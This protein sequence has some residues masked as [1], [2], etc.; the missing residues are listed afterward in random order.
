[1]INY[2][3]INN[4][5]VSRK[6]RTEAILNVDCWALA[7]REKTDK[8]SSNKKKAIHNLYRLEAKD[9]DIIR[10]GVTYID[11]MIADAVY[12][13]YKT[14]QFTFSEGMILRVLSGD[15]KQ[16]CRQET[17]DRIRKSLE[18]MAGIDFTL[19]CKEEMKARERTDFFNIVDESFIALKKGKNGNYG[20]T[21]PPLYRYAETINQIIAIP[22]RLWSLDHKKPVNDSLENIAIKH[23]LLSRIVTA[24]YDQREKKYKNLN[25]IYYYHPSHKTIAEWEHPFT[26]MLFDLG[27]VREWEKA[28]GKLAK[29]TNGDVEEIRGILARLKNRTHKNTKKILNALKE[30]GYIEECNDIKIGREIIGVEIQPVKTLNEFGRDANDISAN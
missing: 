1:M 26:G 21:N 16:T 11:M 6:I 10:E 29:V 3:Y 28:N 18:K 4:T 24:N 7:R 12:S 27:V 20:N 2:F 15:G 25:K 30:M 13:L 17:K 8:N 9:T 23:Y 19:N 5:N 14:E 22:S